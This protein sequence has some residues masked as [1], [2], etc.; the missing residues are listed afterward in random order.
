MA[1]RIGKAF[2]VGCFV[3]LIGQIL[4]LILGALGVGNDMVVMAAMLA[5]GVIAIVMIVSGFYF[6]LS[7]FGGSGAAIPVCGLM[8]GAAMSAASA[9]KSGQSRF[10]AFLIGFWSVFRVLGTGFAL[11][12]ILGLILGGYTGT[13]AVSA[14]PVAMQL[15][16][17]A[18]IGGAICALT[19][20]LTEIKVNFA[21]TAILLMA[22]GGG[23]FTKLGII[24]FLNTLGAGGA[25]VTALGCGNGAY[26]SGAVLAAGG[27]AVIFV[28][29][30]LLNIVL[31]AMGA[32]CGGAVLKRFP[33]AV[34]DESK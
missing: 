32:A 17:A 10:K 33:A 7:A 22:V 24:D 26:S 21:L 4:I 8:F 19:Q 29:V 5:F 31:V 1:K 2:L 20:L 27:G 6:K 23:V 30:L 13:P 15:V 34:P 12:F 11:A 3:G 25:S 9:V 14:P 18:V 16:W 28:M